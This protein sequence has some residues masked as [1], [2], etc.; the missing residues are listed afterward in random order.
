[1]QD[2]VV[3][4]GGDA[5]RVG[6]VGQGNRPGEGAV[7]E[8]RPPA[9]VDL[10]A[11]IGG[12]GKPAVSRGDVDIAAWIDS[13]ELGADLIAILGHLVLE[14]HECPGPQPAYVGE[15]GGVGDALGELRY[16][17]LQPGRKDKG[18]HLGLL[19]RCVRACLD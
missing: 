19:S 11:A 10:L 1:V 8:F 3:V 5:V 2:A 18:G 9:E 4:G 16:Q 12:D 13:W 14:P 6:A 15:H 17:G 7:A